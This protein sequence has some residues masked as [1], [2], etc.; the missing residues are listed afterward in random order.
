[1]DMEL[2]LAQ[3]E[4]PL[5]KARPCQ[6]QPCPPVSEPCDSRCT[7]PTLEPELEDKFCMSALFRYARLRPSASASARSPFPSKRRSVALQSR[8][9]RAT[10]DVPSQF[11]HNKKKAWLS[12]TT[13]SAPFAIPATAYLPLHTCHHIPATAS[14]LGTCVAASVLIVTKRQWPL[15][16]PHDGHD[17]IGSGDRCC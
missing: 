3:P 12:C 15:L 17:G 7:T 10:I 13:S 6:F 2:S 5:S 9:R 14:K 16:R 11:A 1:M 4:E 8:A